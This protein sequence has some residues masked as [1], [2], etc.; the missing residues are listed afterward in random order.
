METYQPRRRTNLEP[1][2][3]WWKQ[4]MMMPWLPSHCSLKICQIII[5]P[6]VQYQ[7]GLLHWVGW[8]ELSEM[9]VVLL[10][11]CARLT[12]LFPC[13]FQM[14]AMAAQCLSMN[15]AHWIII[16]NHKWKVDVKVCLKPSMRVVDRCLEVLV[17][18]TEWLGHTEVNPLGDMDA[19]GFC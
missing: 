14:T 8:V 17:W 12:L 18:I 6:F 4:V 11:I 3:V 16:F 13:N 19:V 10:K 7:Q 2:V 15:D 5:P 1:L 9:C